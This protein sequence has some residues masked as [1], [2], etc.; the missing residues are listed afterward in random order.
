MSGVLSGPRV[1]RLFVLVLFA[2]AAGCGSSS[3]ATKPLP[4]PSGTPSSSGHGSAGPRSGDRPFA[5][6]SFWNSPLPTSAPLAQ[7]SA[8][9]VAD[10]SRQIADH[11]V[12]INT[13]QYSVPVF[14][15][16]RDQPDV[17]VKLDV[18]YSALQSQ[19][20]AVPIPRSAAPAKG[21]DA[22]MVVWQPSTNTTWEF[23]KARHD[24]DGWH[25]RWGGRMTDVNQSSGHFSGKL[26]ATA[27][28]LP[29][30]GGLLH[31]DE[32]RRR[33]IDHAVAVGVPDQRSGAFVAPAQ[34]TDAA[35]GTGHAIVAGMRF[36]FPPDLD[37]SR[38]RLSP[39]IRA[40]A[41][42][43]QRYGMIVRDTAGTVVFYAQDPQ[44]LGGNP[45]PSIFGTSYFDRQHAFRGFP[46][47][48]LQV[49]AAPVS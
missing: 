6:S 47:E 48:K 28:G 24:A 36:R 13:T 1:R 35:H 11:N 17:R 33:R 44:S 39:P 34:R 26:G 45:Y 16:A 22:H 43:I 29:L 49:V 5:A 37:L 38:Y 20:D 27:T 31:P 10:L 2:T 46:W 18:P 15:A 19:F 12:W 3:E 41:E 42:A 4:S 25:A 7:N 14:T 21:N 8:A 23:F 40:I 32:L 9:V 30:L